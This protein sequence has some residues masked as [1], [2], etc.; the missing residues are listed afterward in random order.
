M[1]RNKYLCSTE[2]KYTIAPISNSRMQPLFR[3]IQYGVI[4]LIG[5]HIYQSGFHCCTGPALLSN[6]PVPLQNAGVA[7]YNAIHGL[8]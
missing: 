2:N 7:A 3:L 6:V 4:G 5:Y 1:L 8:F